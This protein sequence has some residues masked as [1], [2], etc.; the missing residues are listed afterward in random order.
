MKSCEREILQLYQQGERN[1]QGANLKGLCFNGKDLSG[2]DFSGADIRGTNFRGANLQGA[3]FRGATAGLQKRWV[4]LLLVGVFI[5]AGISGFFTLFMSATVS[6]IFDSGNLEDQSSG[7]LALILL[8]IFWI[9]IIRNGISSLVGVV[10]VTVRVAGGVV[11]AELVAIAVAIAVVAVVFVT[12][13]VVFVGDVPVTIVFA[14]AIVVADVFSRAAGKAFT[15]AVFF[16]VATAVVFA[17]AVAVAGAVVFATAVA[18]A[19]GVAVAVTGTVT[20][21]FA[22][23][24]ILLSAYIA[25]RAMKGD[26][27]Y[28]SIRNVAIAFAAV[29]GTSFRDANLTDTDFTNATLKS[30]D[31]RGADIIR[32]C[33]RDTIKLD[34]IRPGKTYLKYAKVTELVKTGE[35]ENIN[36]NRFNLQGIN[37]KGANLTNANFIEAHLNSANLRDA[38]LSG[39]KLVGTFLDQADLTRATLTGAYIE[40]WGI[41]NTTKLIEINCDYIFLKLPTNLVLDPQRRPADLEKKFEPGEFAKLAQKIPHTVT[42]ELV[43]KN[44]I[45]WQIFRKTFQE[46]RVESETEELPVIQTIENKGDGAFVIRVKV[47]EKIDEA[48]YERKFWLKYKQKYKQMWGW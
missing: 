9:I 4:I 32:T 6:L 22:G 36:L 10:S 37:L 29:G 5:L 33:W 45:D 34:R 23:F 24:Q 40:D 31:F 47:S 7:L 28:T 42:V 2:A 11:F 46:L 41:S 16:A 39:A 12:G 38:N 35:G 15:I 20:G 44:S 3:K 25:D 21:A 13:G 14:G 27:K 17:A 8:I 30:T 1:F 48:E 26:E 43:F 18:V 19:G